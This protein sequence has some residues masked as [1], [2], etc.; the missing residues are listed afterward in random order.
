MLLKDYSFETMLPE[1]NPM[2]ETINAVAELSEDISEALPYLA[3]IIK[4]CTYDD[5]TKTLT[6]RHEGKG[7]A[8]YP[9]KIT[10]TKLQDREE[11][12]RVLDELKALINKTYD[13]RHNI[14]PRYKK[15][16]E[17]KYLE[18]FKLLPGTNCKECGEP[19]CL[20]FATKVV[21]QE[22]DIAQCS[23]LFSGRFEEKKGKL[24]DML[25]AAGYEV[26]Q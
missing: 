26:T 9:R 23:P 17:L 10:V 7:V 21:Q 4:V 3:S 13:H 19:T 24:L 11:A 5:N 20:A 18:V 22:T 2:A 12:K 6:F 1:C 15:G 25:Q 8:V 14:Q 16:G